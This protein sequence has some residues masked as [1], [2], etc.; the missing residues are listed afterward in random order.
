MVY[1]KDSRNYDSVA[2]S[3]SLLQV[4]AAGLILKHPGYTGKACKLSYK[5]YTLR[6]KPLDKF[7]NFQCK[8]ECSA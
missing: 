1:F 6:R 7:S 2:L 5:S 3:H 4:W 8:F